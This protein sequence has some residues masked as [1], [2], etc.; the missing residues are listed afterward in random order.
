M[1]AS[2]G[3]C[4][5]A[6]Q[7]WRMV[8]AEQLPGTCKESIILAV[9]QLP[10]SRGWH[11]RPPWSRGRCCLQAALHGAVLLLEHGDDVG[12]TGAKRAGA[13]HRWV[14]LYEGHGGAADRAIAATVAAVGRGLPAALADEG[15]GLRDAAPRCRSGGTL[16]SEGSAR[17]GI[18]FAALL[19]A[20]HGTRSARL[21]SIA[22]PLPCGLALRALL[23]LASC[24]PSIG[25]H[26]LSLLLACGT[27]LSLGSLYARRSVSAAEGSLEGGAQGRSCH[28]GGLQV[29]S[30]SLSLMLG[31]D[32]L[33]VDGVH[34]LRRCGHP[35]S[36]LL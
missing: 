9:G 31:S 17:G 18:L 2:D 25:P 19:P 15:A 26:L 29:A 12:G 20:L 11:R 28:G 14:R 16:L 4:R 1:M 32:R 13:S 30:A 6:L 22:L 27:C 5:P 21:E 34:G 10:R 24:S 3:H 8:V 23:S 35:A 33:E 7:L 36:D